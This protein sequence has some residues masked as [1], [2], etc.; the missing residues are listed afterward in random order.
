MDEDDLTEA[1][2]RQ[3]MNGR[4]ANELT[5]DQRGLRFLVRG[6]TADSANCASAHLVSDYEV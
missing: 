6:N 2:V 3:A 4:I 1:N 5:E